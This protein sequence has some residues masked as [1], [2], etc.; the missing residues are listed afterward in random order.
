MN[1]PKWTVLYNIVSIESGK[2]IGTGWE[3]FDSDYDAI[4]CFMRHVELG[5]IPTKRPYD[6]DVDRSHLGACHRI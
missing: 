4:D 6:E 5:N 2:W 1:R 3:F